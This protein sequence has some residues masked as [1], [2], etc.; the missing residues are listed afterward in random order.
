[1]VVVNVFV[2]LTFTL[3][4]DATGIV[5]FELPHVIL[6]NH[7]LMKYKLSDQKYERASSR[8]LSFFYQSNP[9][10]VSGYPLTATLEL[11]S[12][13]PARRKFSSQA[14]GAGFD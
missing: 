5:A 12:T 6:I 7:R 1:M 4:V 9:W 8:H 13:N 14:W 10:Q 11:Y 2:Y 3:L